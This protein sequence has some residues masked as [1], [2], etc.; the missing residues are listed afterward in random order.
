MNKYSYPG[1][2][3]NELLEIVIFSQHCLANDVIKVNTQAR[4]SWCTFCFRQPCHFDSLL[5]VRVRQ[6]WHSVNTH[7]LPAVPIG[8]IDTND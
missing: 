6:V 8:E 3:A 5:E 1:L 4:N 2:V 7:N